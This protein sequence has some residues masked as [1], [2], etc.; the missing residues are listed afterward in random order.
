MSESYIGRHSPGRDALL[1]KYYWDI[2]SYA[3][4]SETEYQKWRKTIP[5]TD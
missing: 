1:A 2:K 5:T 4:A 3:A